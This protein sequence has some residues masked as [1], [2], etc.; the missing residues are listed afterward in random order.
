MAMAQGKFPYNN[1]IWDFPPLPNPL[2]TYTYKLMGQTGQ[3]SQCASVL[4][5][6]DTKTKL[7]QLHGKTVKS[8]N[9]TNDAVLGNK[10]TENPTGDAVGETTGSVAGT[11]GAMVDG[12]ATEGG[13]AESAAMS[14]DEVLNEWREGFNK[15]QAMDRPADIYHNDWDSIIDTAQFFLFRRP[16]TGKFGMKQ[17]MNP[18]MTINVDGW[19]YTDTAKQAA[20]LGWTT[21][22]VFG[23]DPKSP[24]PYYHGGLIATI[25]MMDLVL[26]SL[27]TDHA[28]LS[29]QVL[30]FRNVIGALGGK[31][32]LLWKISSGS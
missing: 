7:E 9:P 13:T 18:D 14:V 3:P 22:E 11:V 24:Y 15:L 28:I 4:P 8:L 5:Q 2:V 31:L 29:S 10:E 26:I 21:M 27:E 6:E 1:S 20:E 25:A 32:R 23:I 12:A 30:L 17:H 19:A 16:K